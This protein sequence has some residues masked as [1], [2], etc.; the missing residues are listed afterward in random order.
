MNQ[1]YFVCDTCMANKDWKPRAKKEIATQANELGKE[2][3]SQLS[4]KIERSE[5]ALLKER[6]ALAKERDKILKGITRI[7]A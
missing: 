1:E 4:D 7:E 5:K 3:V 6:D 2:R